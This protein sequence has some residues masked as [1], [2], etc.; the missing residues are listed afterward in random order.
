M[1]NKMEGRVNLVT[2]Y[3]GEL[4]ETCENKVYDKEVSSADFQ[5]FFG[6]IVSKRV[7]DIG[8]GT[9]N[10]GQFLSLK[11][12]ECYGITISPSEAE[13]ARPKLKE[14]VVSDIEMMQ[15]LPFPEQFLFPGHII[16]SVPTIQ[17]HCPV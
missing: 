1:L 7:L 10:L 12:N 13:I 14:V 9:G 11:Q 16:T 15:S 4:Q 17:E 8:C 3:D 6:D 2:A 5:R